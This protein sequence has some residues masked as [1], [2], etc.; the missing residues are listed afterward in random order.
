M[1]NNFSTDFPRLIP[2]DKKSL[3]RCYSMSKLDLVWLFLIVE[4]SLIDVSR[5]ST[6]GEKVLFQTEMNE[7]HPKLSCRYSTSSNLIRA[8]ILSP[9]REKMPQIRK[10]FSK[11]T[12]RENSVELVSSLQETEFD[13]FCEGKK[14]SWFSF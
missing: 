13:A 6:K 2:R 11:Q 1:K 12:S 8:E 14:L 5:P 9:C 7:R 10:S 4:P 3:G